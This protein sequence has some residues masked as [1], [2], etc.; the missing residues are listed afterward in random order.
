MLGSARQALPRRAPE[1]DWRALPLVGLAALVGASA[2]VSPVAA[3]AVAIGLVFVGVALHNLAAALSLFVLL[4]FFEQIPGLQGGFTLV[5]VA[6]GVL[7]LAWL[8]LVAN[9]SRPVALL[10][11]DHPLVAYSAVAFASLALASMLWAADATAA[12]DDALRLAQ[13]IVLLFVVYSAIRDPRE[14]RWIFWAYVAGAVLTAVV[15]LVQ[16]SP[17][18]ADVA[19]GRLTG[20]IRDPNQ[21]AAV[22]VPA[23]AFATFGL[24]AVRSALGRWILACAAAL[25]A[26]ALFMTES[27]GGLVALGVTLLAVLLLSGPLRPQALAVV[28]VVAAAGVAYYTLVAPPESLQRVT[29]FAAG[30]GTGRTDLWSIGLEMYGDHPA[31]GVGAGNFRVVEPSYAAETTNVSR[32][33]FILDTPKGAHNTYLHVLTELG[34]VG[35]LLFL[36][37]IGG[38]LVSGLR[39]VAACARAGRREAEVLARAFVVGLLG[40]LAAYFFISAQFEKQLWLLLGVALALS[41]VAKRSEPVA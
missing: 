37:L 36:T 18:G 41:T 26:L 14:L 29:Q 6:G 23:L 4:T 22:L 28:F 39:A 31:F 9:R 35:L 21:L 13:G 38:A 12:R 11:R 32:V 30:G 7:V 16:T 2:V 25:I 27:R 40:V 10:T 3:L 8:L 20:G 34:A 15:G 19:D 17:E 5:K 1:L 24:A 33:E